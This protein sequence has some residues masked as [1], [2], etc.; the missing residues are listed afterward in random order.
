MIVCTGPIGSGT[1]LLYS[2]VRF[3]LGLGLEAIHSSLPSGPNGM[4]YPTDE[5]YAWWTHDDFPVGARFVVI[6]RRPDA[7]VRAVMH[8]TD[9][10]A[11]PKDVEVIGSMYRQAIDILAKIPNAY[12][13]DYQALVS[14]PWQQVENL[15]VWL[16]CGGALRGIIRDENA[17]WL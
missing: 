15:G 16:G 12:W 11:I 5:P 9:I 8:R 4:P 7:L 1:R 10:P 14:D 13:V 6:T 17:K 3:D 2:I